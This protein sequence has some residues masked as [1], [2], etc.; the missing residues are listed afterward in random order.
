MEAFMA[1]DRV[2][3]IFHEIQGK[4]VELTGGVFWPGTEDP[5]SG[6]AG[7]LDKEGRLRLLIV[8]ANGIPHGKTTTWHANGKVMTKVFYD[9]GW[10][11][12]KVEQWHPNGK[13]GLEMM[14]VNRKW[15]SLKLWDESGDPLPLPKNF[16][17]N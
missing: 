14:V 10:L 7:G 16:R 2:N 11:D 4:D 15:T 8:Y 17:E 6:K 5:F 1:D 9:S 3:P 13:K 12:G